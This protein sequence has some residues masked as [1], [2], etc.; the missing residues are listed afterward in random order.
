LPQWKHT[1]LSSKAGCSKGIHKDL[2]APANNCSFSLAPTLDSSPDFS[3]TWSSQASTLHQGVK[4][5][6]L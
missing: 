1:S 3:F 5:A 4:I 6:F 2:A